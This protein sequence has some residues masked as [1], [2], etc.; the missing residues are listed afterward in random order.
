[1]RRILFASLIAA[2]VSTA[3]AQ[4][5]PRDKPGYEEILAVTDSL[6]GSLVRVEYT[7]RMD[8]GENPQGGGWS[9]R[10]P[11]CGNYHGY[12]YDE[13]IREQRPLEAGGFLLSPTL[14]VTNDMMMHP[15]FVQSVKVRFGQKVVTAKPVGVARSQSA[16]FL[17][18]AE[19]LAE[20]RPLK[21]DAAAKAPYLAVTYSRIGGFWSIHAEPMAAEVTIQ[22]AGRKFRKGVSNSVIVAKDGTPVAVCMREE[23]PLD[24]SWKGSPEGWKIVRAEQMAGL[25]EK[26]EQVSKQGIVRVGLSFRSPRQGQQGMYRYCP[27]DEDENATERNVLGLL[28]DEQTVLILANLDAKTTARLERIVVHPAEGKAVAA[29]F[30]GTL[31]DYGA[32]VA[33]LESPMQ[34]AIKLSD[35]VLADLPAELLLSVQ[36]KLQGENRLSYM[37]HGRISGLAIGWRQNLYPEM[38]GEQDIFLFDDQARLL[39]FPLV[40]RENVSAREQYSREEPR[41]TAAA[42]IQAVVAQLAQHVDA[43]NVPLTQE[44]ENRLAWLG[45]ELQGLNRELARVNHVSDLT[46]DGEAGAIVSY[47][48]PGSPAEL[49]GVK[50][51]TILIRIQAE[52]EPKPLN[53]KVE[54]EG[55][56]GM[57]FPWDRLDDMPE[58]FYDRMP[59]PWTSAENSFTRALTDLGFGAKFQAEFFEDGKLVTRDFVVEQSPPYYDSAVRFKSEPLG[60]T[61]RNVTYELRRYFQKTP[62][63]PGVI[64]SKV[65]PGSKASVAGIRPYEMV[66]SVNETPVTDVKQFEKLI[67]QGKELRLMINRMTLGRV[68]KIQL[69]APVESKMVVTTQPVPAGEASK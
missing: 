52:G 11:N 13:V 54:E 34:G 31:K 49:A 19:P 69:N 58:E 67:S 65:E 29:K 1:M 27:R 7:L 20:A 22:Q 16:V 12:D 64:V 4:E 48:Y 21:F 25:L 17:E 40:R 35:A 60:M 56:H 24:D 45:V 62:Q 37:S 9:E 36:M 41:T 33:R 10:C 8:K 47:I 55:M 61:V 42:Q 38:R 43:S 14:V 23:L 51:G 59:S 3:L 2:L 30:A 63:D 15:R 18:L 26:T 44:E 28:M 68:V 57:D 66:V 32:L 5:P 50:V 6:A 39:A 46:Q 53:V